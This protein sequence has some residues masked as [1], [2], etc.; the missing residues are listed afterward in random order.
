MK[1]VPQP[2]T[3]DSPAHNA[4]GV[5][6]A[7]ALTRGQFIA[8]SGPWDGDG[9]WLSDDPD[10]RHRAAQQCTGCPVLEFCAEVGTIERFGVWGGRDRTPNARA[11]ERSTPC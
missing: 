6:L 2:P 1:I 7:A 5:A 10:E 8:C 11:A 9:P 3:L 4:L